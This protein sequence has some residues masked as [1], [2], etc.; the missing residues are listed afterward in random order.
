MCTSHDH[1]IGHIILSWEVGL[2]SSWTTPL[3]KFV[4]VNKLGVAAIGV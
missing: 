4:A 1:N 2:D 3:A